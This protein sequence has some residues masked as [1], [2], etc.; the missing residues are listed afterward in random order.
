MHN[1]LIVDD[2]TGIRDS[3]AGILTDEGYSASTVESGEACL[4]ALRKLSLIHI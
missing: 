4:D 1:V 2:E 3:L